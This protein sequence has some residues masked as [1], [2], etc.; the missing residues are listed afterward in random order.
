[1]NIPAGDPLLHTISNILSSKEPFSSIKPPNIHSSSDHANHHANIATQASSHPS[2]TDAHIMHC[3]ME[4]AAYAMDAEQAYKHL[5]VWGRV[6]LRSHRIA[7]PPQQGV[8]EAPGAADATGTRQGEDVLGGKF[9]VHPD[10]TPS[11][12]QHP[13]ETEQDLVS[14]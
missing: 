2:S 1:M 14:R 9:D 13:I 12:R 6:G 4:H 5:L 8:L 10:V 11:K 7:P 3:S